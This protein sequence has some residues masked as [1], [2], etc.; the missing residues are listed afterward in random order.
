MKWVKSWD[1]QGIAY[2]KKG[3]AMRWSEKLGKGHIFGFNCNDKPFD[4]VHGK[5]YDLYF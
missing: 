4:G 5:K 1:S 3:D 2:F